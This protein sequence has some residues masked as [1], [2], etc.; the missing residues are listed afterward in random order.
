MQGVSL[1]VARAQTLRTLVTTIGTQ[2][3][4]TGILLWAVHECFDGTLSVGGMMFLLSMASGLAS[5]V[6][7]LIGLIAGL[8]SLRPYLDRVDQVFSAAREAT[9]L[10]QHPVWTS[11]DI[12]L[13]S[14]SHRYGDGGRWVLEDQS[15]VI[16]K[17]TIHWLE[18]PSGSGKTTTL[19]LIA[20]LLAPVRGKVSV[21]GLDARLARAAVLYVPQHCA[22][23]EASIRENLEL[24]SG[25]TATDIAGSVELSGLGRLLRKF[26]MGLETRVSAQGQNLSS[27]QRQLIVLTAAF[28][29]PRPILLLDEA[30]SQIDAE[31]RRGIAWEALR[32][33][34]TVVRVEHG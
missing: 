14:V 9:R 26:P 24:L 11:D 7:A 10:A 6:N 12:M 1:Q 2:L 34:R 20:G 13:E 19:R 5:S 25:G 21:F 27:G 23:F 33:D 31:T 18:S 16:R 29:S 15:L 4:S 3:L 17:G 32:R 28:A 30:T 22:L 8:R